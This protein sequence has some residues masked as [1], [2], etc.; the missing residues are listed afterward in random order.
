MFWG[1]F[2][3]QGVGPLYPVTGMMNAEKYS[4]LVR[5]KVF[6]EMERTFPAGGGIFQQDLASSHSAKKV[7][8]N[9]EGKGIKVLDRP[10]NS[11]DVNPI[12]NVWSIVKTRLLR[13]I[14][15]P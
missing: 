14:A 10:G 9:F 15:P 11:P 6:R 2:S 13:K 5:Q 1:R 4:E 8:K 12:E 7:K 3:F